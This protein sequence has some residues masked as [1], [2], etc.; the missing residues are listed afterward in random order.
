MSCADLSGETPQV[1]ADRTA[2]PAVYVPTRIPLPRSRDEGFHPQHQQHGRMDTVPT[3]APCGF[4]PIPILNQ[5]MTPQSLSPK[6]VL[7]DVLS[8]RCFS[9]SQFVS[10]A[11][12]LHVLSPMRCLT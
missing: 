9:C 6:Q 8:L 11:F 1:S 2:L 12:F 4:T 10:E 3:A 5:R 7:W